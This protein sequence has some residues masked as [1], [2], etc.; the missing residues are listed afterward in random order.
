MAKQ[1]QD[2]IIFYI[3]IKKEKLKYYIDISNQT[4]YSVPI[5]RWS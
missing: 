4:H 3:F 5:A 2:F 1:K